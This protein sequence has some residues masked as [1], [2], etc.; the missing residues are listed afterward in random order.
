MLK[1][2]KG[3]LTSIQLWRKQKKHDE[4]LQRWEDDEG[5]L[6]IPFRIKRVERNNDNGEDKQAMLH[7]KRQLFNGKQREK[8]REKRKYKKKYKTGKTIVIGP[9]R[10]EK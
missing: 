5:L 7:Q 6:L 9:S 4:E 3:Y 10:I 8:N 2:S 1:I